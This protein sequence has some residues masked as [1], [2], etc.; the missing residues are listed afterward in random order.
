MLASGAEAVEPHA[1]RR[2]YAIALGWGALATV[3]LMVVLLGVRPDLAEAARLPMFWMK[4]AFP[5]LI[6]VAALLAVTRLS[7]PGVRLGRIPAAIAA[8]ILAV[9]VLAVMIL[10]GAAPADYNKDRKSVV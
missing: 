1:L 5:A 7:R 2:R 10:L 6:F 3:F 8:P 4:P 9:W